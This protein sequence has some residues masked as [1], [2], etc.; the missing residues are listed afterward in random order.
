MGKFKNTY[1]TTNKIITEIWLIYKKLI[2]KIQL[3]IS[4]TPGI[5][6]LAINGTGFLLAFVE[7]K[8]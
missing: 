4:A 1:S 6:D 2:L 8:S 7:F 3:Y 5:G